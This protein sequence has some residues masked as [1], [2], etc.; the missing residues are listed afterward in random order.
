MNWTPLDMAENRNPSKGK[1]YILSSRKLTFTM[2]AQ[3]AT[4]AAFARTE[5]NAGG[6][7]V[8]T[9]RISNHSSPHSL[10]GKKPELM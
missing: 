2:S 7:A 10:N 8:D 5:A 4:Q 1:T 9:F 3:V 6:Q